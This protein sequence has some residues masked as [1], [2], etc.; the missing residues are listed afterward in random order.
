M[1]YVRLETLLGKE[2]I[3]A[4]G[5]K[6]GRILSV[7]GVT[8]GPQCFVSEYLLGT[9]ALLARLGIVTARL[10]GLRWN[11]GPKR[12]PWQM[13]DLSDPDHPRLTVPRE[14]LPAQ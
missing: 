13:M 4:Q 10:V 5:R 12:I 6:V 7:T 3:D 8:E 14:Q 11:H 9:G 2:V 1:T